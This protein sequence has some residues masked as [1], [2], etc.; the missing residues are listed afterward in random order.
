VVVQVEEGILQI[1]IVY[2]I[3]IVIFLLQGRCNVIIKIVIQKE[4]VDFLVERLVLVDAGI[5]V[6]IRGFSSINPFQFN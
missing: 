4:V 1:V 5:K 6:K 2:L 3:N